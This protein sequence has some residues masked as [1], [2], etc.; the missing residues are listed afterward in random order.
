MRITERLHTHLIG[1]GLALLLCGTPVVASA[2][3]AQESE[4]GRQ[5]P[6][7]GSDKSGAVTNE[8]A[9]Q[10]GSSP[11]PDSPGAVR[12]QTAGEN[13]QQADPQQRLL[14]VQQEPA[15]TQKPV[16]TAAAETNSAGGV[17][18][19]EPAGVAIAPAKQRRARSLLI[20]VGA[21]LGAG[22][23]LG[24]V[25]ALSEASPSKPPGSH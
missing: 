21:V 14:Q 24:T 6:S 23:A 7:P 19:S 17:A 20:K 10:Q 1:A 9:N 2:I 13:Q 3:P 25:M 8:L 12:S 5:A 16:G 22:V 15:G 11:L 18:A 4:Q